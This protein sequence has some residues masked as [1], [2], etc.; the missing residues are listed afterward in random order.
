MTVTEIQDI[1]P[2]LKLKVGQY[3]GASQRHLYD[4]LLQE[5]TIAAWMRLE[6]GHSRQI[7]VHKAKQRTVDLLRGS[8]MLGSQDEHGGRTNTDHRSV[9]LVLPGADGEDEYLVEPEDNTFAE[10]QERTA[11][12][13]ELRPALDALTERQRYIIQRVY[14][15]GATRQEIADEFGISHQAVSSSLAKAMKTLRQKIAA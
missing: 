7:A 4:D 9:S 11:L 15:E 12:A 3:T 2:L 6:E 13:D 14:W 10:Y 1:V 5:A 8:R